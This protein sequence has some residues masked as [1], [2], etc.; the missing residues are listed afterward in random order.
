MRGVSYRIDAKVFLTEMMRKYCG[1]GYTELCGFKRVE[2]NKVEVMVWEIVG[3]IL[4][5]AAVEFYVP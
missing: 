4:T 2:Q 1:S 5:S 3:P